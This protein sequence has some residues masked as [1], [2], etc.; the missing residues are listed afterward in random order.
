MIQQD[1]VFISRQSEMTSPLP[2]DI[3]RVGY[4]R[5]P[6]PTVRPLTLYLD[7]P[8]LGVQ[9]L[10]MWGV[11]CLY[12]CLVGAVVG[13]GQVLESAYLCA[14]CDGDVKS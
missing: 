7:S 11:G 6:V 3:L 4:R 9:T 14:S 2:G 12:L 5:N 13:K 8:G 10:G 1:P